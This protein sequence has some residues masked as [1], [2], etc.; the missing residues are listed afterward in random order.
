MGRPGEVWLGTRE[1]PAE[2]GGVSAAPTREPR[3]SSTQRLRRR[4]AARLAAAAAAPAAPPAAP[5]PGTAEGDP[6]TEVFRQPVLAPAVAG[7]RMPFMLGSLASR[8]ASFL[9]DLAVG[10]AGVC[11]GGWAGGGVVSA[12]DEA[13]RLLMD[14]PLEGAGPL[15]WRRRVLLQLTS[16]L[17]W[18]TGGTVAAGRWWDAADVAAA[19]P[20]LGEG[21]TSSKVLLAVSDVAPDVQPGPTAATAPARVACPAAVAVAAVAGAAGGTA[22]LEGVAAALALMMRDGEADT[23]SG[24][25]SCPDTLPAPYVS[26][27]DLNLGETWP[28]S[29]LAADGC[30][31]GSWWDG[32]GGGDATFA[33]NGGSGGAGRVSSTVACA[34]TTGACGRMG[35]TCVAGGCVAGS[36]AEELAVDATLG[37]R[38]TG[39]ADALRDVT[40]RDGTA[41]PDAAA[42]CSCMDKAIAQCMG[43]SCGVGSI[44]A[45]AAAATAPATR[46]GGFE[47]MTRVMMGARG[48]GRG[49]VAV[50]DMDSLDRVE[51]STEQARLAAVSGIRSWLRAMGAAAELEREWVLVLDIDARIDMDMDDLTDGARGGEASQS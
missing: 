11:M 24:T 47:A 44:C 29:R 34:G 21:N 7:R 22:L 30:L 5:P 2:D 12:C 25:S 8:S 42:D 16:G 39:A 48:R 26:L 4:A 40:G 33:I 10:A 13:W 9:V 15:G 49:A 38:R 23:G 31:S 14:A 6:A 28:W 35:G 20:S 37:E 3:P 32:A 46:R 36:C 45:A 17:P 43:G 41:L 50:R 27:K 1:A 18:G 19:R 51:R